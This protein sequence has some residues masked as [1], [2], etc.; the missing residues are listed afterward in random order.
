M[1]Y[2][3]GL[4]DI[5]GK[6]AIKGVITHK[7]L[8]LLAR[9]Q[10]AIQNGEA[11]FVDEETGK[12]FDISLFDPTLAIQVA[13]DCYTKDKPTP[14]EWYPIDFAD[15]REWMYK[16]MEI[17]GGM[18]SPLKRKVIWPER[19]FDHTINHTWASY[20]YDSP[21]DGSKI[22]GQLAI[23]GTIDLVCQLDDDAKTVELIDWKTGL[24]KDWN[25]GDIKNWKKLRHDPQ[26]R[27]YHWAL[28]HLL[29]EV[30]HFLITIVFINDGGPYSLDFNKDDLPKTEKMIEERLVQIQN[31]QKP[32]LIYPD[33]KCSKLCHYGKTKMPGSNKTICAQVNEELL[34]I[35]MERVVKKYGNP[36]ILGSYQEGGGRSNIEEVK[37]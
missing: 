22:D 14:F 4:S 32:K 37:I 25:T 5:S 34:T 10:V 8:E 15:C 30:E 20:T 21:W 18:F 19:Y 33:W 35:G 23:K 12:V 16:A 29:P 2:V 27:I 9:K 26:L 31:N 11:S 24:R 3:L 36:K 13:W 7:A 17:N 6:K 1:R 28:A